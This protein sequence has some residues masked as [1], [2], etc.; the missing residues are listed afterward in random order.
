MTAIKLSNRSL[1]R[2]IGL[3][4]DCDIEAINSVASNL[5]G[6]TGINLTLTNK[7]LTFAIS[8]FLIRSVE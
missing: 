4:I 6:V 2:T 5:L 7:L 3:R 1:P 8:S